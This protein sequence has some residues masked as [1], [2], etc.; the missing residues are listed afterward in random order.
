[1]KRAA[2]QSFSAGAKMLRQPRGDFARCLVRE[3]EGADARRVHSLLLDEEADALDET[4]SLPRTRPCQNEHRPQLRLDGRAL[5]IGR[6]MRREGAEGDRGCYKGRHFGKDG[7]KN[8]LQ[9]A[10]ECKVTSCKI[11]AL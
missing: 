11:N 9:V 6:G 5:R 3:R 7:L 2:F 8:E 1:M 10:R 4:E